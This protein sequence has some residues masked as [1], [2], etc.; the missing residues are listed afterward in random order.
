MKPM[1][2]L[3]TQDARTGRLAM[4]TVDIDEETSV[5]SELCDCRRSGREGSSCR[6]TAIKRRKDD[7]DA[8]R[9]EPTH[10]EAD[11]NLAHL[12][13]SRCGEKGCAADASA[14]RD[15]RRVSIMFPHADDR[16]RFGGTPNLCHCKPR[17]TG[18]LAECL[19]AGHR[20]IYGEVQEYWRKQ[21]HEAHQA[22]YEALQ[23]V[24]RGQMR[25]DSR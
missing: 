3:F 23:Q 24:V 9:F 25:D 11:W 12:A 10:G 14:W 4:V 7:L 15:L 19:R 1:L 2:V 17:T 8:R 16:A 5:S 6:I 20:G 22:R 21:A 13:A 18:E